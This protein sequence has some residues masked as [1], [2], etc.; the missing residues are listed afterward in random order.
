MANFA[1]VFGTNVA[2]ATIHDQSLKPVATMGDFLHA[3]V[4]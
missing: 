2:P 1:V 3:L 4:Q